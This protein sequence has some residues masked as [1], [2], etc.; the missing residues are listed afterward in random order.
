EWNQSL[1]T[2][3]AKADAAVQQLQAEIESLRGQ[4]DETSAENQ[5]LKVTNQEMETQLEGMQRELQKAQDQLVTLQEEATH[6][7]E[8]EGLQRTRSI[9][10]R[11]VPNKPDTP[12]EESGL[13]VEGQDVTPGAG[14]GVAHE[15]TEAASARDEAAEKIEELQAE[16]ESL[17]GQQEETSA[18]N[19]QLKVTNQEM[20]MRLEGI[21]RELQEAQDRLVTLQEEAAHREEK[22]GLQRTRSIRRRAVP[23]K[24]DTPGEESGLRVEG[25]DVSPGAGG[26]VAHEEMEA[27][28]EKIEELQAEI[29]SLRGLQEETSAENQQLKVTNQ[30]M[31]MRLEGIQREL[32]EAQDRL[33]TLQEEAAH[34]EE[35]EGLQRT[36]SIRRRAVPDKPDTPEEE[37]GLRVEGQDMTPG[38][39]GDVAHEE[40][41]AASARDEAAGRTEEL[42]AEIES[43]RGLQ[44]E[45]SAENQQLKVTNQEME[46]RLE[47]IQRELQEAQDRLVTLQEEREGLKRT[48][49]IRRR[50]APD[51]SDKPDTQ[52]EEPGPRVEGQGL[53]LEEGGDGI[54]EEKAAASGRDE[55]AERIKELQ[56]EI[57]SLRGLQE[58]TSAE[59]QQLKVTNQELET[60]L[61]GIQREQQE[62]QDRLVSLQEET[63]RLQR[64]P[65]IQRQTTRDTS[66]KPETLGE[67]AGPRLDGEGG[68]GAHNEPAA[69]SVEKPNDP[70]PEYNVIFVG[71]ASVGKTSFIQNFCEGHYQPGLSSTIGVDFRV[72]SLNVENRHI[73]LKVWD[74]AGQ[75]R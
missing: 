35:K 65:S 75:E 55:A 72:K 63:E 60:R 64:T 36:R 40:T 21:Q 59:N 29:E 7:E 11:A 46:M 5:Q 39:G 41:G 9:R 51:T 57:E 27:A 19:Q 38:A 52:G 48:R 74:T 18:E 69:T 2:E 14:G 67:D 47:V 43:L 70:E 73:A 1:D 3:H 49:S 42:Q 30:E 34:Q 50:A 22:E 24:P 17:R 10:R 56:A 53:T 4:Q 44:E 62:I 26:D 58:E 33:V 71:D 32:Q 12:G 45:T 61:E 31:E 68:D 15:E 37:S 13:R 25:Q 66:S 23:D 6:R 16:I 20:E 54:H 8:K 28:S